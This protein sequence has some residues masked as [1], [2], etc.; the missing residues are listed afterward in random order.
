M[1]I[2]NQPQEKQDRREDGSV[3][4]HSVFYTIQGEGPFAGDP[5]VFVRLA[6]CNLQCPA[7]DTEYTSVRRRMRPADVYSEV[8][9]ALHDWAEKTV[10][11]H[12]HMACG[13]LVVITGGEPFR[14]NL[15]AVVA[16]L[17]KEGFRVQIETNGTLYPGDAFLF[18]HPNLRIVCSPKTSV[19]HKKLVEHVDA[20]KYV[21]TGSSIMEDGLP[22]HALEHPNAGQL[23]RPPPSWHGTIY[24][25]PVDEQDEAKNA[26]NRAAVIASCMRHGYRLCLQLHKIIGL[27]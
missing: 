20:F 12:D 24:L 18:H 14:Q 27:D 1:N 19:V 6:G 10:G 8:C 13:N 7:C 17:L 4:V 25:Q 3:V 15:Q 9:L 26:Y 21:A 22:R 2:N 16:Y 11:E 23:F 5:A